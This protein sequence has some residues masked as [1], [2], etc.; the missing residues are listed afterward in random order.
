VHLLTIATHRHQR[1]AVHHSPRCKWTRCKGFQSV[2]GPPKDRPRTASWCAPWS[3]RHERR[4]ALRIPSTSAP[5]SCPA[6]HQ[7]VH[8][9]ERTARTT[10]PPSLRKDLAKGRTA[11][12]HFTHRPQ[13]GAARK[14]CKGYSCAPL[15]S[16]LHTA[17]GHGEEEWTAPTSNLCTIKRGPPGAAW[18][19]GRRPPPGAPF[20]SPQ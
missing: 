11:V 9:E 14:G 1:T 6:F 13:Q 10:W 12:H 15:A 7:E 4:T 5:L 18:C 2:Q 19:K 8:Q 20:N 3:H 16:P 17:M